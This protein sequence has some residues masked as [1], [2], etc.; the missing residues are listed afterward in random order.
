MAEQGHGR[1][2]KGAYNGEANGLSILVTTSLLYLDRIRTLDLEIY[3]VL[4]IFLKALSFENW[5]RLSL[6]C[7]SNSF[8]KIIPIPEAIFRELNEDIERHPAKNTRQTHLTKFS[9]RISRKVDVSKE[10]ALRSTKELIGSGFLEG[11]VPGE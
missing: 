1:I 11:S 2:N 8:T 9:P 7:L 4:G 5:T 3:L 6:S 10:T